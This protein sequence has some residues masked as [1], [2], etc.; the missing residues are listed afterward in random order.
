MVVAL[1]QRIHLMASLVNIMENQAEEM[2]YMT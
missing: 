1:W 2:Q